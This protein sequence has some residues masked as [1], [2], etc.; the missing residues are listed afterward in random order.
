MPA[1]AAYTKA[2]HAKDQLSGTAAQ[3][4][5]TLHPTL[6]NPTSNIIYAD[7]AGVPS[8][9]ARRQ[10]AKRTSAHATERRY[11]LSAEPR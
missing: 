9:T 6:T 10:N 3:L 8:T 11:L 2:K 5:G 7:T 4:T 1:V